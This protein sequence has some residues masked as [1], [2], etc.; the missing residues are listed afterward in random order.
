MRLNSARLVVDAPVQEEPPVPDYWRIDAPIPN[1]EEIYGEDSAVVEM[2]YS[3]LEDDVVVYD[4]T[5][6]SPAAVFHSPWKPLPNPL[7]LAASRC[8]ST[9]PRRSAWTW[10]LPPNFKPF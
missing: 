5:T 9:L 2:E 4:H 3:S 8:G 1:Y 10:G 7:R 6:D